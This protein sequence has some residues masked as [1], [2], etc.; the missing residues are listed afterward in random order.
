MFCVLIAIMV[1]GC[2]PKTSN[3]EDEFFKKWQELAAES[4][5]Y[6]P[7]PSKQSA[8]ITSIR[9]ET[10]EEDDDFEV[11][12]DRPLPKVPVT[13]RFE[14]VSVEVVLRALSKAANLSILSTS[15]IE[16]AV[17]LQADKLP[18]DQVF[19][20]I[21]KNNG[22]TYAWEGKL[23]RV[24]SLDD[25]RKEVEVEQV[26]NERLQKKKE[27]RALKPLQTSIIGIRYS[28]ASALQEDLKPFLTKDDEGKTRGSIVVDEHN[29]ALII[30]AVGED[31]K[32]I[33]K[34]ID[35][36]DQPRA[37]V[38]LKAHIVE[39]NKDTARDLGVQWGGSYQTGRLDNEGRRVFIQ[40]GTTNNGP[41]FDQGNSG[42]AFGL[43]FPADLSGGSGAQLGVLYGI[44]EDTILEL[45]L[46]ALQEDGKLNILSSPSITT[47][48]N[49]TAFTEDG[50]RVPFVATDPEGKL[51]VKFEDAVLRLEITPHIID[52]DMLKL[53]VLIKKDEVDINRNVLGNPF[54]LKNQTETSLIM[55]DGGTV[56]I[57]GLTRRRS[58]DQSQ[59]VPW[60]DEVP[61]FGN[62]FRR[63]EKREEME[64]LLIFITPT[65]LPYKT[66]LAASSSGKD[67]ATPE[68]GN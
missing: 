26:F 25:L 12:T 68:I 11:S 52:Q 45:Q 28:D 61:G 59:G 35:S 14:D 29:N 55:Y 30:Q 22:L 44:L 18:W 38:L 51:E 17:S 27:K 60:L 8:N 58:F 20:G 15:G 32:R 24:V 13:L 43:N 63:D 10:I 1:W 39:T 56:V 64:D 42:Q 41:T 67:T 66:K 31:T 3:K 4:Q 34:L 48:D 40:P 53:K 5:G 21:L 16:G 19:T 50:E 6:S 62:F 57:S 49:Q 2:G 9:E 46:S 65:I 47:L 33:I 36:L 7:S 37:Q 54:I 23:L